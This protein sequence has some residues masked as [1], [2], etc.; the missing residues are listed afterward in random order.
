MKHA[1]CFALI[2]VGSAHASRSLPIPRVASQTFKTEGLYEGGNAA[3]AN[4][5][6]F[7]V[8]ENAGVERWVLD[9]SDNIKRE[10]G[11]VAPHFQ[12]RY[13]PGDKIIGS[14]GLPIMAKPA[15]FILTLR[16][17]RKNFLQRH[18]LQELVKKSLFVKEITVYPPIEEGDTAIELILKDNVSFEPHQP[19][20]KE[21]R[22]VLD[23]KALGNEKL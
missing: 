17:I 20:Q 18:A 9:F 19:V 14:D 1:V 5:E 3:S 4:I 13:L 21:G 11:S 2:L 16:G 10:L 12:I 22:L 7:R 23:L 8:S 6:A 15:K